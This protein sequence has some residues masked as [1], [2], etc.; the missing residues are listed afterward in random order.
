MLHCNILAEIF[1]KFFNFYVISC[2]IEMTV[3]YYINQIL[4]D[5]SKC[6]FLILPIIMLIGIIQYIFSTITNSSTTSIIIVFE[7]FL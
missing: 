7:L 4:L 2:I 6:M 3:P 1:N 5:I